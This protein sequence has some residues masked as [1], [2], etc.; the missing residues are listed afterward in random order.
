MKQMLLT[1]ALT[2]ALKIRKQEKH[3]DCS[4]VVIAALEQMLIIMKQ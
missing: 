3:N 2:V 1:H 4:N